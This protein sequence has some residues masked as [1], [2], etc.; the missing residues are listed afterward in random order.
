ME[1][2]RVGSELPAYEQLRL[3]SIAENKNKLRA[4]VGI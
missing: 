4:P 3:A 1:A 2:T